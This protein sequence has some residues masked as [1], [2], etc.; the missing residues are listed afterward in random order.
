MFVCGVPFTSMTQILPFVFFGVG[1]D[2]AYII[3]GSYFRLDRKIDAVE[4]VRITIDE[5]GMSIFLTTLTSSLAFGLGCIS[6]IPAV[7]WLCVYAVPTIVLILLWQLT[8]FIACLVL[9]ERRIAAGNRDMLRC[10]TC[11]KTES[12][13]AE[14]EDT[15]PKVSSI[16]RLMEWYAEKLLQPVVKVVVV[17]AFIG[18]AVACSISTTQLRQAFEF[19][20]VLPGDSYIT[21]FFDAF[22]DYSVRSSV[23]PFAYFRY[24]DQSD[25]E[26][27]LQMDDYINNLF[28][29]EAVVEQP[30]FCW[31]RAFDEFINTTD[32]LEGATFSEQLDQF[33]ANPINTDLYGMDIV[34]D[35]DGKIITSRCRF[36]MDNIDIEDVKDQINALQDQKDVSESQE[37]N[38]GRDD[39]AFF[40]YD[41][42]FVLHIAY[43]VLTISNPE[44]YNIWAFYSRSAQEVTF[45]TLSSVVAVCFVTLFLVPHWSAALFV[46]PLISVLYIDLLGVLQ[47]A[48][49]AI[50]PVS[51]ITLVMSVSIVHRRSPSSP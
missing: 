49:I 3:T 25:P 7:F 44:Q 8:F 39:F 43:F 32:T 1:L 18:I 38:Q 4:R 35:T 36:R 42:K 17:L 20:D 2:D 27:R 50:N 28:V 40:T 34:R 13:E 23:A 45:T 10:I 12:T 26:I 47:W 21:P 15:L 11:K 46:L 48:G 19:T 51:Y 16:D 22:N 31:F 24:V 29:I 6:T 33:L 37:I 30:E 14:E 5:I 9:D 41:G